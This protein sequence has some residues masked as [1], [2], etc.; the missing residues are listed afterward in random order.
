MYPGDP[1][2]PG[3]EFAGK[4]VAVGSDVT[5]YKVGDEVV[6]IGIGC[7]KEYIL[8]TEGMVALKPSNVS[9]EEGSTIPIVYCTSLLALEKL[10]GLRAGETVLI[11]SAA[12][13]VGLSAIQY[14]K[15]VGARIVATA[16]TSKHEYLRSLGVEL[17]TSSRDA[18]VFRN[19]MRDR[20]GLHGKID[21]VLNSLNGD[22]IPFS[23]EILAPN[24][25]FLEIGK[26][27]IWEKEQVEELRADVAY[28]VIALD[29]L[30]KDDPVHFHS[31][32]SEVCQGFSE[33]L[34]SPLPVKVFDFFTEY[35]EAFHF[36]RRGENIGKVALSINTS[37]RSVATMNNVSKFTVGEGSIIITGGLGG[38]G[39]LT[40]K[41][42]VKLGA[43]HLFLVSRSGK[44]AYE[45]QG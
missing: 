38:L 21:V 7:L 17:I 5:K 27:N 25:R 13:G 32:L 14:A 36:L 2:D 22:F 43:R 31:L 3:C 12:G 33:G 6:G 24:G 35:R 37:L 41:V 30:A 16:S 42:L 18:E 44:I 4:V 8:V 28:H 19:D 29:T 26:R 40:A 11:H 23:L 20:F 10:A 39:L 45:G 15:R 9:M 34:W 1:G